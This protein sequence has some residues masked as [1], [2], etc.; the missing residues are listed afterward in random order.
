M[1]C[2]NLNSCD[3]AWWIIILVLL[4]ACDSCILDNV[5]NLVCGDNLIWIILLLLLCNGN[6]GNTSDNSG[7]N[8]CAP[9]TC[10]CC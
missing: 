10:G 6:C 7:C 8:T 9:T 5:R 1:G 4:F 3:N 2:F